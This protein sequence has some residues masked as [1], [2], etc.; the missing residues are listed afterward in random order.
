[1]VTRVK[2]LSWALCRAELMRGGPIILFEKNA[3]LYA[4]NIVE[5]SIK[6]H[7]IPNV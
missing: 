2:E 5:K 3:T 4:E 6:K 7:D 1:M